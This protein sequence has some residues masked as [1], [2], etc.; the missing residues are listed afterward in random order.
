MELLESAAYVIGEALAWVVGKVTGRVFKMGPE[1]AQR[2][3]E[4]FVLTIIGSIFAAAI[5]VTFVYS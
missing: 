4:Y 1:K 3:G 2:I 5:I